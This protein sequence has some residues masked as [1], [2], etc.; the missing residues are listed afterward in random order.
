MSHDR[1]V[2]INLAGQTAIVTGGGRGIGKAIAMG[3]GRAGASVA[4]AARMAD[5]LAETLASV[6]LLPGMIVR[7]S[8]RIVNVDSK[9]A[10]A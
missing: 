7:G 2:G 1:D 3:L 4:V 9:G 10:S 8:G 6:D 5:R